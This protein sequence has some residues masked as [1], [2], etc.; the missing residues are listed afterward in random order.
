MAYTSIHPPTRPKINVRRIY[1]KRNGNIT[2]KMKMKMDMGMIKQLISSDAL[3]RIVR[4]NLPTS[5]FVSSFPLN[6]RSASL[7]S[8]PPELP[9]MRVRLHPCARTSARS[10]GCSSRSVPPPFARPKDTPTG[11]ARRTHD[12]MLA[13]SNRRRR[14]S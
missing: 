6:V 2:T 5:P 9:C 14:A 7:T 11:H 13:S 4:D 3:S 1:T 8:H 10:Q 12:S